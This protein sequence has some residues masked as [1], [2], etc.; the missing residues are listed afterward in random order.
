MQPHEQKTLRGGGG[1]RRVK[2]QWAAVYIDVRLQMPGT[3]S[4]GSQKKGGD[5]SQL[6]RENLSEDRWQ[7]TPDTHT[8]HQVRQ[9][10]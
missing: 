2:C 1:S 4:Q 8:K 5:I 9:A 7:A 3:G 6:L 10:I